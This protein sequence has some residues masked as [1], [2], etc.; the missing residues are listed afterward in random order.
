MGQPLHKLSW[1]RQDQPILSAMTTNQDWCRVTVYS[2]SVIRL[3]DTYK[4][5]YLGNSS[6]TRLV[7]MD[8]GYAESKDGLTWTEYASNPILKNDG[9]PWEG[10]WQTP[11]VLFDADEGLYKMWFIIAT[12]SINAGGK[13]IYSGQQLGYATS[14]DGL[15]WDVH[16]E[17]IYASGRRPCVVK[18]GPNAYRMWMCSSP[19]T[20]GEFGD[21]VGN[22]YRF[23]STNG[24]DWTRDETPVVSA[25]DSHQSMVYPFV[26]QDA[27]GYTLWYGCHVDG[28]IFEL[29]C[30]T[31]PDGVTWTHHHEESSFPATRNPND[32]DGRYTST[33]YVL[34]DG[35]RYLM[36]YSARDPGNLYRAG[37]GTIKFDNAGIYRHIGVAVC[38][39]E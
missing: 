5:W 11:H 32:F 25:T 10:M 18:D 15:A 1:Q 38:S 39:K 29:F 2:P 12:G 4:M 6:A 35:D 24:I 14:S 22:I 37:D 27:S 21:L 7:D 30:S 34:D 17:P 36:Y 20:D 31:S 9:T 3:G 13:T 33:P 16:P 26:M 23:E 8:M 19:K 28:G